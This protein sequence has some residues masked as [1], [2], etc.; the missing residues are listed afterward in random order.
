MDQFDG[1]DN[2][3]SQRTHRPARR[4]LA[5]RRRQDRLILTEGMMPCDRLPDLLP[6]PCPGEK[7]WWSCFS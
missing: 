2:A 3:A 6:D 5:A 1:R 7:G 4:P